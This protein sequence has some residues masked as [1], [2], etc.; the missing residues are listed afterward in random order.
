MKG[1]SEEIESDFFLS[2]SRHE[3]DENSIHHTH[4][5]TLTAVQQLSPISTK[6]LVK[7]DAEDEE[8][9]EERKMRLKFYLFCLI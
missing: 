7:Q 5:H 3:N 9:E 2:V 1:A 8:D 4:T 6:V